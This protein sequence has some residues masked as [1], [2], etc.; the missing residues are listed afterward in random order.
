MKDIIEW[1]STHSNK[2]TAIRNIKRLK[3]VL[4][5][6]IVINNYIY[7]YLIYILINIDIRVNLIEL[8]RT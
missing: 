6:C 8:I 5:Y 1:N 7:I 4:Y 2:Y 3:N